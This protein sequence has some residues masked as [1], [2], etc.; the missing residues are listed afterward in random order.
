MGN[1]HQELNQLLVETFRDILKIEE[2]S[3]RSATQD[4]I[5]VA[6]IHTLEAIGINAEPNASEVAATLRVAQSTLTITVN[7]LEI[8]GMVERGRSETDRRF[9]RLC[10]TERGSTMVKAHERFHRRMTRR[11]VSKLQEDEVELFGKIL[12]NLRTFFAEEAK[13]LRESAAAPL[14]EAR[15][16]K[17]EARG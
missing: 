13:I 16:E 2:M 4:G 6:E 14:Q 12:V 11:I 5:S 15:G 7:R 10:L 9:V 3:V 17:R 8:K 1:V